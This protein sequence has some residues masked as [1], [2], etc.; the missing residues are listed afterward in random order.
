MS[1]FALTPN[2]DL[3]GELTKKVKDYFKYVRTNGIYYLW[4]RS[5]NE[6]LKA[7]TTHRGIVP[8]TG[9]SGE[10]KALYINHYRN[11]LQHLLT[12]I[13]SQRPSF[14][15]RA[16][17]S[18]HESM[19]Q[20]ILAN[21]LLDY[22]MREKKL[23][24]D[25]VIAVENSLIFGEAFQRVKWDPNL[26]QPFDVLDE[27]IVYDGDISSS[28]FGPLDV[29]RDVSRKDA[30]FDWCIV[31]AYQSKYEL[32]ARFPEHKEFLENLSPNYTDR[33]QDM[34]YITTGVNTVI[35]G[36]ND[37]VPVYEFYH[38]KTNAIIKG[39]YALF[40]EGRL[41]MES[42]MPFKDFPVF[43]ISPSDVHGSIFGYTPLYDVLP[44]QDGLNTLYSS[45][46]T[47]QSNYGTQLILSPK[48]SG[49]N[50]KQLADGLSV[51]EYD[52]SVGAPEGFNVLKT[53]PELFTFINTLQQQAEIVSG[54]NSTVRG[55]A[56]EG[57]V[58]GV[59]L[60]LLASQ[61]LSFAQ[62]LQRSF[63]SLV[64]DVGTQ[65]VSLTKEF[66]KTPRVAAIT[67][68]DN[69]FI[70]QTYTG[71]DI[72]GIDRVLVDLGNPLNRTTAGKV[73]MAQDFLKNGFVENPDQYV[74]VVTTGRLEP[75]YKVKQAELLLIS[76][77]NEAICNGITPQAV[78]TDMHKQHILE[79]KV[80]M[81]SIAARND[82]KL[83]E[84]ATAH[85]QQHE[86]LLVQ[87][88]QFEPV[89]L[90]LLN[91]QP[92]IG[93]PNPPPP[94]GQAGADGQAAVL[95][96]Q[97]EPPETRKISSPKNPITKE[98]IPTP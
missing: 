32:A 34:L 76:E 19:S 71:N 38:R 81:A 10:Y 91:E 56:P 46:I 86:D 4:L 39:R 20:A 24:R 44:I 53:A 2:S 29:I 16:V 15:A 84:A 21:S 42:A 79:H 11:I 41:L 69:K 28:V 49:V 54:V 26:G 3:E 40:V 75:V 1:Y 43:R 94:Q 37:C 58:A 9:P 33:L 23:D 90:Q 80:T 77:E 51:I 27:K 35:A 36:M 65:I 61:A 93:M 74:Q 50:Y 12:L 68:K 60:A 63:V 31:R 72:S 97:P 67:G 59:S 83:V 18:D 85:I 82:P 52:P 64:E 88:T 22:Y 89:L 8:D 98:N 92:A 14:D 17:N 47:N 87:L 13:T 45:I 78:K 95:R 70:M 57:V 6:Y 96:S 55:Q 66:A 73:T 7:I 48:G 25:F 62:N 5:Y 30:W